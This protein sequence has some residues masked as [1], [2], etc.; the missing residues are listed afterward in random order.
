MIEANSTFMAIERSRSGIGGP[1]GNMISPSPQAANPYNGFGNSPGLNMFNSTIQR[2]NRGNRNN[3]H[4]NL[5]K[6]KVPASINTLIDMN[7]SSSG[8]LHQSPI[9]NN[10]GI[11]RP[12][13]DYMSPKINKNSS[14]IKIPMITL[15]NQS[16]LSPKVGKYGAG[17]APNFSGTMYNM[18]SIGG[19]SSTKNNNN[20]NPSLSN[21]INS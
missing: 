7:Q 20:H 21:A 17:D 14:G 10:M 6:I 4:S 3:A 9:R 1:M 8:N 2:N 15:H 5:N 18:P 13:G 19:T 16:F 12:G 11:N